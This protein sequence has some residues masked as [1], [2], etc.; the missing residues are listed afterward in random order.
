MRPPAPWLEAIGYNTNLVKRE[1]APKSYADLLDPKWLAR[2]S[3]PP[4]L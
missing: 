2:S 4:R 3:R 1:D